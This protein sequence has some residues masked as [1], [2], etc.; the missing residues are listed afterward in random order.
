MISCHWIQPALFDVQTSTTLTHWLIFPQSKGHEETPVCWSLHCWVMWMIAEAFKEDWLQSTSEAER[1]KWHYDRK[2]NAISLEPGD[3]ILAK[4]NA[5]RWIR[6]VKDQW[7]EEPYEVEQVLYQNQPFLITPTEGT[8]L[9]TIMYAKQA[10][11]TTTTLEVK[12]LEGSETHKVPQ[13]VSSPSPAQH[14][15]GET[16]IGWVNRGL[17]AFIRM[18]LR[19]PC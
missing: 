7:E 10:R 17:W 1:Q 5:Y 16:P 18:F 2:A 6:K 8:P 12:S 11:C 14:Q 9:C 4:A 3:L 15:T 19:A 13:S